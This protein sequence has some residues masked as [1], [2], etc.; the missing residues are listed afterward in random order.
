ME[1][2]INRNCFKRFIDNSEQNQTSVQKKKMK[3][4]EKDATKE[5]SKNTP[6]MIAK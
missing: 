3:I 2:K 6:K 4:S 1:T 5:M